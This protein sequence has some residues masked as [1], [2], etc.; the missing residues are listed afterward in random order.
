MMSQ[1]LIFNVK[2]ESVIGGGE[3][4]GMVGR[5][6]TELQPTVPPRRIKLA[7]E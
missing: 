5:E 7:L 4:V 2:G 3:G 6:I 1:V